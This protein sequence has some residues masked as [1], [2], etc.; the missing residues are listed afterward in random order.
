MFLGEYWVVRTQ[1]EDECRAMHLR[2]FPAPPASQPL[3]ARLHSRI[4]CAVALIRELNSLRFGLDG[5]G[6]RCG[7]S[8]A[9][10]GSG[11]SRLHSAFL[12]GFWRLLATEFQCIVRG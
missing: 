8:G 7:G 12:G 6:L 3:D 10:V 5:S 9:H 2:L 4:N 11:I 1:I